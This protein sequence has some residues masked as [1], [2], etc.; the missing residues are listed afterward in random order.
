[1]RPSP[2]VILLSS[3]LLTPTLPAQHRSSPITIDSARTL[4]GTD[5]LA[6]PDLPIRAIYAHGIRSVIVEQVLNSGRTVLFREQRGGPAIRFHPLEFLVA[7]DGIANV[8]N[9][10]SSPSSVEGRMRDRLRHRYIEP[11]NVDLL[12]L[13]LLSWYGNDE[14]LALLDRLESVR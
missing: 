7:E 1:M 8:R 14:Q 12:S 10:I 6:V 11:L 5:P 3:L 4:L 13:S 2:I 9:A